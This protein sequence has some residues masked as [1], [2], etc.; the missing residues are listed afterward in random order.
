MDNRGNPLKALRSKNY[1][2][3]IQVMIDGRKKEDSPTM[4]KLLIE[5]DILEYLVQMAMET[6][7]SEG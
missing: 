1:H 4:K 6:D 3:P 5:A 7:A 2:H